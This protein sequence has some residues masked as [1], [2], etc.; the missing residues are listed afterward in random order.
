MGVHDP[1]ESAFIRKIADLGIGV[2]DLLEVGCD[3]GSGSTLILG[4]AART[5]NRLLFCVD[6][7]CD[8][9]GHETPEWR[10]A[11][12][13]L[14]L[15]RFG[16]NVAAASLWDYVRLLRMSSKEAAVLVPDHR[17]GVV[18]IDGCH[19]SPWVEYDFVVWP[20]KVAVGG[21]LLAHDISNSPVGGAIEGW[22]AYE[23]DIWTPLGRCGITAAWQRRGK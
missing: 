4:E 9:P 14:I 15:G 13:A 10:N 22:L 16:T 23:R 17:L 2:G 5:H 1:G 11:R 19:E 12:T 21:Y 8:R 18:L 6:T 20:S 3:D 7:F